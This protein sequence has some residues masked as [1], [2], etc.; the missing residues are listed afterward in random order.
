MHPTVIMIGKLF[1]ALF[2]LVV[3][4]TFVPSSATAATNLIPAQ[5]HALLWGLAGLIAL[6]HLF[7]VGLYR[8]KWFNAQRNFALD[9]VLIS[10]FGFFHI[11]EIRNEAE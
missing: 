2:W 6:A 11:A 10:V 4:A 3:A 1:T 5:W 7:E 8:A 9:V